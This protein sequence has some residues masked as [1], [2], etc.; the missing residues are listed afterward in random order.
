VTT[1]EGDDSAATVEGS[2]D[3]TVVSAVSGVVTG[4]SVVPSEGPLLVICTVDSKVV[5]GSNVVAEVSCE[6][7][8]VIST[9]VVETPFVCSVAVVKFLYREVE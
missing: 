7:D 6:T 5:P 2:E 3:V 9:S 8:D 4:A 1:G